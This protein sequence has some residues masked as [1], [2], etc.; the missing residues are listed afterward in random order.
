MGRIE[1]YRDLDAWR[2]AMDLTVAVYRLSRKL[3]AEER[4]GLVS[5]IRRA[6]TSVPANIAEGHGRRTTGEFLQA[7]SVS[8]GSLSELKTHLELIVRLD[9]LDRSGLKESWSLSE[10]AGRLL[11]G[12]IRA[13]EAR[14]RASARAK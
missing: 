12:L 3:P 10:N 8:R 7:L 9:Y 1:S 13:L 6:A 14:K 11:N 5:Q 4:F 2:K